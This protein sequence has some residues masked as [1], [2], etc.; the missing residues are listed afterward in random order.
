MFGLPLER[1]GL[2]MTVSLGLVN[3]RISALSVSVQTAGLETM[4]TD[5]LESARYVAMHPSLRFIYSR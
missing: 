1:P 4:P 5:Q 3:R 2:G